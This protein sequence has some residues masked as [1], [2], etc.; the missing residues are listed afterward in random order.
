M[1]RLKKESLLG[2]LVCGGGPLFFAIPFLRGRVLLFRDILIFAVPQQVTI[3][4]EWIAGRLPEWNPFLYGGV[5]LLAEPGSGVF[6]PPNLL[7]HWMPPER[8]ATAFVLVHMPLAAAGAYALARVLGL[9]RTSAAFAALGFSASGFL[10]SM[11]GGHYYFASTAW[12]PATVA[13]LVRFVDRPSAGSLALAALSVA[14]MVLNGELQSAAFAGG[15]AV[16]MAFATRRLAGAALA[17]AAFF[18]G[19]LLSGIQLVPSLLFSRTTVRASG[20]LLEQA[21]L[22]SLHPIRWLEFIIPMPFGMPFPDNGF[23]GGALLDGTHP[24]PWAVSLYLGAPLAILAASAVGRGLPARMKALALVA[25]LSLVIAA[26]K[27]LPVFA[28]WYRWVPLADRFRYPAKF[29]ALATLAIVLLAGWGL[30]RLDAAPRRA[31][32]AAL[33]LAAVL[34]TGLGVVSSSY[35][36]LQGPIAR[37]L[38]KAEANSTPDLAFDSLVGSVRTSALASSVVVLALLLGRRRP[39][40]RA[41]LVFVVA[42][43]DLLSA[44]FRSLSWG[45]AAFMEFMPEYVHRAQALTPPGTAGRFRR[46][47]FCRFRMSSTAGTLI[48]R[49][50]EI[51]WYTGKQN[52]PALFSMKSILGYGAAE[53]AE[54]VA[55]FRALNSS[56]PDRADRLFGAAVR[57]D[58]ASD[59]SVVVRAVLNPLPRASV[60]RAE[61]VRASDLLSRLAQSDFDPEKTALIAVDDAPAVADGGGGEAA[62]DLDVPGH[63]R[64]RTSG[65]GGMMVFLESFAE[66]WEARVDGARVAVVRVD[67]LW[68]GVPVDGGKHHVELKYRTPGLYLGMALTV[69]GAL[70]LLASFGVEQIVASSR[71]HA[72]RPSPSGATAPRLFRGRE[73]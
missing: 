63:V 24:L 70:M 49:I 30:E 6:Y 11:H 60:L 58:C 12:L 46:D 22:W 28:L 65:K 23:W 54:K 1:K 59:G 41:P 13:A 72:S 21:S 33:A 43:L 53:L 25:P 37:G 56:D 57:M 62:I 4:R 32:R 3:V 29:A 67:G 14:L 20:L 18:L 38:A 68:L 9:G 10:L 73:G 69:V 61:S 44:G 31:L 27:H 45:S 36:Q 39:R 64:L 52:F 16:L 51:D 42:A 66:G 40:A 2:W 50:R 7:F 35:P 48:E 19:T 5:P 71:A 8:A 26:G 15:L 17:T 34:W 55:V 47:P